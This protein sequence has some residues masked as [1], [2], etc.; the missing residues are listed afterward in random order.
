MKIRVLKTIR[1]RVCVI[2]VSFVSAFRSFEMMKVVEHRPNGMCVV[3]VTWVQSFPYFI[4]V[5]KHFRIPMSHS[6][7]YRPTFIFSMIKRN[8]T[9]T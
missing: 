7:I 3:T 5:T 1:D 9:T 4:N 6:R 2:F 8:A